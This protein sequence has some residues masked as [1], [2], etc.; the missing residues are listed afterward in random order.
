MLKKSTRIHLGQL[1]K[2]E[3]KLVFNKMKVYGVFEW[4]F[5]RTR[6]SRGWKG[7]VVALPTSDRKSGTHVPTP[8]LFLSKPSAAFYV[9]R[10]LFL[11]LL[12]CFFSNAKIEN[13]GSSLVPY[14]HEVGAFDHGILESVESCA[15]NFFFCCC[16]FSYKSPSYSNSWR[17]I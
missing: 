15:L 6:D 2:S 1:Q 11:V 4:T 5:R 13:P 8:R 16:S 7:I 17:H 9:Y 14:L 10:Y 3:R 12:L